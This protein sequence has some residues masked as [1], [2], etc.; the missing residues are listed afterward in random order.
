VK[1]ERL[2]LHVIEVSFFIVSVRFS[3]TTHKVR[4][5]KTKINFSQISKLQISVGHSSKTC[6][7]LDTKI[8]PYYNTAKYTNINI[9]TNGQ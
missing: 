3:K 2:A 9:R 6:L 1:K 7:L 8:S 4:I 5:L